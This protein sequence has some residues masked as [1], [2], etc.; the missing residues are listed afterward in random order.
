MISTSK[1]TKLHSELHHEIN[2]SLSYLAGGGVLLFLLS[3]LTIKGHSEYSISAK[4]DVFLSFIISFSK[5]PFCVDMCV[6]SMCG[7]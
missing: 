4:Y 2:I 1:T 3:V 6:C 5:F 7:M